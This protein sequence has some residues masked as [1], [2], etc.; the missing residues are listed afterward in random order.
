VAGQGPGRERKV[1]LILSVIRLATATTL[2]VLAAHAA[3]AL[4]AE[5][6]P[7][8][9]PVNAEFFA[10]ASNGYSATLK[11]EGDRLQLTLAR[12]L[13]PGLVYSFHGRVS[14]SGIEARIADLGTIDLRFVAAGKT[15]RVAPPKHCSGPEATVTEG[16][17]LG[18]FHFRAEGGVAKVDLAHARGAIAAPGWHCKNVSPKNIFESA[19]SDLGYTLLQANDKARQVGV[20][21]ITTTDPQHP[22]VSGTEFSASM[23]TRRG[24]VKVVHIAVALAGNVVTSDAALAAATATPPKPFSGSATFCRACAAGSRWTGDLSVTLPGIAA[25]VKLTGPGYD[26]SF[27][28]LVGGGEPRGPIG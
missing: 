8:R 13:F 28:S 16:H 17:F 20:E 6:A 27:R 3:P 2:C 11:S 24:P 1:A 4:A 15:K 9:G 19:P 25:P 5:P 26:V 10:K 7:A 14:A 12:G 22:G 21:A 18:E 23:L